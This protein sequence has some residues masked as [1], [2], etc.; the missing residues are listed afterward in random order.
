M[1]HW[2]DGFGPGSQPM[3]GYNSYGLISTIILFFVLIVIFYLIYKLFQK[4]KQTKESENHHALNILKERY[5][6]GE[7]SD[8]EYAHMKAVLKNK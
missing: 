3:M 4:N 7:L 8:E 2:N 1:R 5:A 6:K